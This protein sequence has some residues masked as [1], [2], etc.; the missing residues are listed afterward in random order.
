MTPTINIFS[1]PQGMHMKQKERTKQKRQGKTNKRRYPKT[2]T[3]SQ[4]GPQ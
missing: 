3:R 1:S 2:K 4:K